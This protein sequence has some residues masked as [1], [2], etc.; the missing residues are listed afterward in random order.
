[1]GGG[2]NAPKDI[3]GTQ[4][5][6]LKKS[7]SVNSL[8]MVYQPILQEVENIY[9]DGRLS[10]MILLLK[11]HHLTGKAVVFQFVRQV[12]LVTSRLHF[13]FFKAEMRFCV[14]NQ[15]IQ[16]FTQNLFP[17]AL[18]HRFMQRV[19]QVYQFFVLGVDIGNVHADITIPFNV[20]HR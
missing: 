19:N 13:A 4:Y 15:F 12:L 9:G 17:F 11:V 1:M 3:P 2:F 7:L 18:G 20:W 14:I 6:L 10:I 16:N 5:P 8:D